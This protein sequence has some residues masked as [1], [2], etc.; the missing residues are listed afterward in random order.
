MRSAIGGRQ[1]AVGGRQSAVGGYTS[2]FCVTLTHDLHHV[3]E[4]P[5]FLTGSLSKT[6]LFHQF[7]VQGP[8]TVSAHLKFVALVPR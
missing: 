1:S 2:L 4:T 8:M 5:F 3:T 6:K 7:L